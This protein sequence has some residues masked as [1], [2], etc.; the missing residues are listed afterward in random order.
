MK[1]VWFIVTCILV[2][3]LF[4]GCIGQEP[5]QPEEDNSQ[6]G[7]DTEP[8]TYKDL[9]DE[10]IQELISQMSPVVLYFYSPTCSTCF[11]VKPHVEEMQKEYNLDIIWVSKQDN[12]AIFELYHAE[13][14]PAIYVFIDSEVY[15]KFDENDP[16]SRIYGQILDGTITGIHRME[17]TVSDNQVTIFTETVVPDTLYYIEIDYQRVFVFISRT[18]KLFVFNGSEGCDSSWLFLK[19]DLI[20]NGQF[21]SQWD[22]DTLEMH[23]ELCGNLVQI[24][25]TVTG[26]SIV[27]SLESI[28]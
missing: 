25:Y 17:Y 20:Y 22:R 8:K 19:K 3:S 15:I 5:S 28:G 6:T 9:T 4:V 12:K 13:Y 23:S 1:H 26:S 7:S 10:E 2:V 16:I 18:A 27:L 14:Y 11:A 21:S 24:P